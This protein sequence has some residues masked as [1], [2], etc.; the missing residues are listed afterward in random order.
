MWRLLAILQLTTALVLLNWGSL[1]NMAD[2]AQAEFDSAFAQAAVKP[3][4]VIDPNAPLPHYPQQRYIDKNLA[5][6]KNLTYGDVGELASAARLAHTSGVLPKE[7]ADHMLPMA[8]VEGR[9]GNF[10]INDGNGFRAVPRTLKNA[11]SLGLDVTDLTDPEVAERHRFDVMEPKANGE[12]GYNY[13]KKTTIQ[14][15]NGP[16]EAHILAE[17][18]PTTPLT[19]DYPRRPNQPTSHLT[20][21]AA[22]VAGENMLAR[23][24]G[25]KHLMVNG[26]GGPGDMAR[27]MALIL[28][29][30]HAAAGGDVA[31]AVKRYNGAGP[32]TDQYLAK[33][34]AAKGL[35]S[36]PRNAPI[37]QHFN[38][39][40]LK[41]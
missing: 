19:I 34:Q 5:P 27:I 25:N 10:G 23:T 35:L 41:R 21:G 1:R 24:P 12:F 20:A 39:T 3:P 26:S 33:V 14:G 22:L 2:D 7:L 31:G 9:P 16:Q 18:P 4:R 8:M 11:Q 15:P 6:E 32:A 38:S 36:H 30:K 29:E 17:G 13:Y 28:A 37:M 40:Y